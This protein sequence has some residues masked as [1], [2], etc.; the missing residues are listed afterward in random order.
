MPRLQCPVEGCDWKSQ[1]LDEAFAAGLT[2][3]LQQLSRSMIELSTQQQPLW[4]HKS[5]SWTHLAFQQDATQTSGQHSLDNGT[6]IKWVWLLLTTSCPLL[7]S[8]AAARIFV[9]TSCLTF[10]CTLQK[11]Q[12]P[13]FWLQSRD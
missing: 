9:L 2:A 1:D 12:K 5:S 4:Q 11:W 8:I 13:I 10:S 3:A 6:C 7:C